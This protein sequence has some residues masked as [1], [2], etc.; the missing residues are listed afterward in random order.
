MNIK[1]IKVISHLE[2]TEGLN[3]SETLQAMAEV[4]RDELREDGFD[5]GTNYGTVRVGDN[6]ESKIL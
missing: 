5:T 6:K 1:K 4:K 2:W 3:D